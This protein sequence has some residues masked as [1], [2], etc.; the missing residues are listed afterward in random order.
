MSH[1]IP[2]LCDRIQTY[3]FVLVT[4]PGKALARIPKPP[5]IP[6]TCT[7]LRVTHPKIEIDATHKGEREEAAMFASPPRGKDQ[8][9]LEVFPE[10]VCGKV[11]F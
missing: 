10:S 11:P 4:R 9:G 7:P 5:E 6:P 3:A 1:P 2:L 8:L